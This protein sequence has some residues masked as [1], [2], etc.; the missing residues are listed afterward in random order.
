[1][2][3]TLYHVPWCPDCQIVTHRLD[4]LEIPYKSVIVPD[5]RPERTQVHAVSGQYYVPVLT[6]GDLVLSET[7]D[8]LSHLDGTDGAHAASA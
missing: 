1:M 5:A 7:R 6:D 8:I 2:A 4:D 3:M